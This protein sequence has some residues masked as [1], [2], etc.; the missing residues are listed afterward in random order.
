MIYSSKNHTH[1]SK[2][3]AI[4]CIYFDIIQTHLHG[5]IFNRVQTINKDISTARNYKGLYSHAPFEFEA[6][7]IILIHIINDH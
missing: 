1:L 5:I 4:A 2:S 6:M 7:P 3:H